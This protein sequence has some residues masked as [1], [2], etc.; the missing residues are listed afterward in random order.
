MKLILGGEVVR[1]GGG[2]DVLG[3]DLGK[4]GRVG[5]GEGIGDWVW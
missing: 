4:E 1:K 2:R 5:M 3:C